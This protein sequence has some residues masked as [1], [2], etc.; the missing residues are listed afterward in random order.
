MPFLYD[1]ITTRGHFEGFLPRQEG[2]EGARHCSGLTFLLQIKA[3]PAALGGER[4]DPTSDGEG[5]GSSVCF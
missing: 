1:K 2:R 5:V 4:P 3:V